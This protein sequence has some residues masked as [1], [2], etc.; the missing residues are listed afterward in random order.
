M[1]R[2]S[3]E[4]KRHSG[5]GLDWLNF[6]VEAVQTSFG[7]F[8]T[9]YLVKNDWPPQAIG[10]ALTIATMSSLFSQIPAG[11]ALDSIHDKRQAVLLG[12]V[13]VGL[14]ALLLWV[15]AARPAVYL[16][17]A[18]QGLASSLIGPG[19]AAI[20][21]ALV[22]QAALSERIGR[23][24]RFA[25]IGNGLAAGTMGVAGSYLPTGSVFLVAAVLVVP[26]I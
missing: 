18:L 7:A 2:S 9:V 21:L 3:G 23:N 11:A 15:T 6:F 25:S 19:V 4:A 20:S 13:G 10:L 14:A 5:C 8:A 12:I 16:A 26:A 24:A 1:D 17:L 22:G